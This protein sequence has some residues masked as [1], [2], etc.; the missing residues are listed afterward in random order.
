MCPSIADQELVRKVNTSV[1]LNTMRMNA[2]I[3]RADL[4]VRTGLNRSTISNI[5]NS[6]LDEGLVR[7]TELQGSRV[8][9]PAISLVLN[10]EGGA[11][12]GLEIGVGFIS[13]VLTDF[14][15]N[16][17]WRNR[18]VFDECVPHLV[19]L[20]EAECQIEEA[21]TIARQSGLRLLGIGLGV[22]G[23]VDTN[24][25]ELIFAPN[26]RWEN[27][28]FRL[29]WTQRFRLPLYLENEANAA[30]L[31]EYY[32]GAARGVNNFIYLSSGIGLGGGLVIDGKL[33][34][35]SKG[36]AGEIGHMII[37]PNG[38]LCGC[39]RRG[40]W[41]TQVGPRAVLG[42]VRRSLEAT[43]G[44]TL[45]AQNGGDLS[46]LTFE[47]VVDAALAGDPVCRKAM[48]DV[49]ASLGLGVASLVNIF[50][51]E[52]VILGGALNR[53]SSILIPVIEK[54]V[55]DEALRPNQRSLQLRSSAYVD[56]ACVFGT[57]AMVMDG[58]FR[59]VAI[60]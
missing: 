53:G 59:E 22:P 2:P 31:C 7:E 20:R 26:L 42:R 41:E 6:L 60:R 19:V 50:N 27:I 10:N 38:E 24:M 30:A 3:S 1:V 14:V 35:G 34:R 32:F 23:L 57:V 4:A 43:P 56:D 39:G 45:H 17:L 55:Q 12:I 18:V 37:E 52:L 5:I 13:I 25:G 29:M 51:P 21:L 28:P 11:I 33:F 15:A 9:R 48:E 58:I 36:F 47:M 49:A 44:S 40:C 54:T 16:V 8:G 46:E